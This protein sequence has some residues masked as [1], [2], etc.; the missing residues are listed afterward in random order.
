MAAVP[1]WEIREGI[2]DAL[3][4]RPALAGATVDLVAGLD[5]AAEMSSPRVQIHISDRTTPEDE[6]PAAAGKVTVFH[7]TAI[8]AVIYFSMSSAEEAVRLCEGAVG[9]AELALMADRTL[10]GRVETLWLLGGPM[11]YG[12]DPKGPMYAVA[13]IELRVK[14]KARLD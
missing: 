14:A 8:L 13:A 7:V 5:E 6:Q 4:A 11:S 1:Y 3:L 10:G 12:K 9:E 2:R